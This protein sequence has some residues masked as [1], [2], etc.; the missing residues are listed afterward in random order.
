MFGQIYYISEQFFTYE[1]S[2]HVIIDKMKIITIPKVYI[3]IPASTL[4]KDNKK[5]VK[6]EYCTTKNVLDYFS[7]NTFINHHFTPK[8]GDIFSVC[9]IRSTVTGLQIP[10][11]HTKAME[12]STTSRSLLYSVQY[13]ETNSI[14]SKLLVEYDVLYFLKLNFTDNPSVT[15]ADL[16]LHSQGQD[17]NQVDS[18]VSYKI[19]F[20]YT[21]TFPVISFRYDHHQINGLEYPYDT[22]C[23]DYS[24]IGF[25]SKTHCIV[26]CCEFNYRTNMNKSSQF[27]VSKT[28]YD[29]PIR[30]V[31]A[32]GNMSCS[33]LDGNRECGSKIRANCQNACYRDDCIKHFFM[34]KQS[35]TTYSSS[36]GKNLQILLRAPNQLTTSITYK[37]RISLIDFI[38]Y[39]L[40]CI[41]FWLGWSPLGFLQNIRQRKSCRHVNLN[42]GISSNAIN[43][44]NLARIE[45]KFNAVYSLIRKLDQKFIV[46]Q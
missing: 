45:L 6:G 38:T 31:V 30:N 44:S 28:P 42:N 12:K 3:H 18:Y 43:D 36:N 22:D 27:I 24:T 29:I 11:N 21:E 37:P 17:L 32:G 16:I 9:F 41:S 15:E 46:L 25:K 20:S 40:S 8:I 35:Y 14:K 1:T 7:N 34:P 2:T 33:S 13:D 4:F 23:F 10:C 5:C 39:L 19:N 26:L